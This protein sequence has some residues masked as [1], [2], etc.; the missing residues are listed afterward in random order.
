[1]N[2]LILNRDLKSLFS[3]AAVA[4]AAGLVSGG[5]MHPGLLALG[6]VGGPQLQAGVSGSR[7]APYGGGSARLIS[8]DGTVPDYVIGTDW[9]RP[10]PHAAYGDED[11][12]PAEAETVV[13]ADAEVGPAAD[14]VAAGWEEPP[15]EPVSFPSTAG[16]RLYGAD[17]PKPPLPPEEADSEIADLHAAN[18]G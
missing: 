1:M 6:E 10:P 9:L 2:R 5:L 15:R 18:P 3:G 7:A 11:E 13:Y 8:H 4:V 16:G 17:L 12:A 14:A